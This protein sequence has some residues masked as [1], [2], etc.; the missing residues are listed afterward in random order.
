MRGRRRRRVEPHSGGVTDLLT[1]PSLETWI[2]LATSVDTEVSSLNKT[3]S[4]PFNH[5]Q[6]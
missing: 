1:R 4:L 3:S 6:Q 2:G 5:K